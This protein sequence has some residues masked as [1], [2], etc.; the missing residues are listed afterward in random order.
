MSS[1]R[2]RQE[3]L[4][5]ILDEHAAK[6][7]ADYATATKIFD[8]RWQQ[9]VVESEW[10]KV[11]REALTEKKIVG[12]HRP[13]EPGQKAFH[14]DIRFRQVNSSVSEPPRIA[15][16]CLGLFLNKTNGEALIGDLSERFNLDCERYGEARARRLYLGRALKAL[17]PLIRRVAARAIKW[18]VVIVGVRRYF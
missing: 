5:K 17:W 7:D 16:F 13:G 15:E 11:I 4:I 10:H 14:I 1:D 18:G 8:A 12:I 9:A 3:R 6:A 2:E